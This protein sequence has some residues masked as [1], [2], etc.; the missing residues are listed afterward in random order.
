MISDIEIKDLVFEAVKA[1][2]LVKEIKGNIY[3][4]RR[5]VDSDAE[6]LCIAV[7]ANNNGEK[8]SAYVNV[9]IY[10]P[11]LKRRNSFEADD[12]RLRTLCA[13]CSDVFRLVKG[14][15]WRITLESQRVDAVNGKNEMYINNR[16]LFQNYNEY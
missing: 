12:A 15:G 6:D 3:K 14:D 9:N 7:L 4:R 8:Q 11:N 13:L 5:L 2:V 16:L 10:V 1:S